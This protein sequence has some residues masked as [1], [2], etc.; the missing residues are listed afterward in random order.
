M[1]TIKQ[2]RG[3]GDYLGNHLSAND[4]YSEGETVIGQWW[5]KLTSALGLEGREVN[6]ADFESLRNNFH[7]VTSEKLRPRI[8]K[9]TFHDIVVSAPKSYSIVALVGGDERLIDGFNRS[10]KK[11]FVRLESFTAARDRAG[12]AYHTEK[13]IRTAN[14]VAAVFKH[15]TSRL[16]DPQLHTHLVFSNHTF[17]SQKGDY[18]ALQPKTMMDEAKKWITDEF[19]QDLAKEAVAAGY[20]VELVENRMRMADVSLR[21]EYKFSKRTQQRR[22]FEKRYRKLFGQEPSKKRIEQFIKEGRSAANAR[23]RDEYQSLFGKL[24]SQEIVKVFVKDWRSA[25]MATTSREV[26]EKSRRSTLTN[27]DAEML[28]GMVLKAK[29][30]RNE[31]KNETVSETPHRHSTDIVEVKHQV[32]DEQNEKTGK[33]RASAKDFRKRNEHHQIGIGRIEA[34]RRMRRGMAVAQA[35]RGHPMV[36]MIHQLSA[37]KQRRI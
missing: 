17:S 1:I 15:D 3:T 30:Y 36:F 6:R 24:P 26:I 23:F 11:A 32:T 21:L 18:L 27:V 22:A 5:G 4:Y 35:L 16:L 34:M 20:K 19:H 29:A 10:V 7:P 2:I 25:K 31:I 9:V 8:S 28:D 37:L 33:V 12:N 14:A 13:E